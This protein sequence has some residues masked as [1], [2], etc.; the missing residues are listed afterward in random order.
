MKKTGKEINALLNLIDDPDDEVY[1]TVAA[2]IVRCGNII[3]PSLEALWEV[4][5]DEAVQERIETLIHRVHFQDLQEAMYEWSNNPQATLLQGALLVARYQFPELSTAPIINQFDQMRKNIWLELNNYLT[6]IEQV[7]VFATMLYSYYKLQGHEI[8]ERE[9]G[10]F[11]IN[12]VL[13]SR[14]GNAFSLGVLFLSLCELLDIPIFAVDIPRQFI[15]A[16]IDTVHPPG[17]PLTEPEQQV[18]FFVD[19][20]NAMVYTRTDVAVYLKKIGAVGK[21]LTYFTPIG[22][23]RIIYRMLEELALCYRYRREEDKAQEIEQLMR[24]LV[25]SAGA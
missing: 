12:K 21:E 23:R 14:Q 3:I 13:E 22:N 5:P 9:P 8:S 10:Y 4:T 24:V 1:D 25:G 2:E 20:L 11:F 7:N 6:P 18:L 16:Y 19:P 15:F 17:K